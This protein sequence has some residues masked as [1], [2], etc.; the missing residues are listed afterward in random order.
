MAILKRLMWDFVPA[1][2]GSL[3]ERLGHPPPFVCRPYTAILLLPCLMLTTSCRAPVD[4]LDKDGDGVVVGEDC[5]DNDAAIGECEATP[6]QTPIP[7]PTTLPTATP[8][9]PPQ[10]CDQYRDPCWGAVT[11]GVSNW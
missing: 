11:W 9:P 5:D 1:N 10:P 3:H 8:T 2:T 6:A 7:T 4:I